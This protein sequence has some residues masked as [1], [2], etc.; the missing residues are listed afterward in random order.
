MNLLQDSLKTYLQALQNALAAGDATEHTHRPALEK[1]FISFSVPGSN[2]VEKVRYVVPPEQPGAAVLHQ[3]VEQAPSPVSVAGRVYIN[4]QQF[5]E[6][7]PPEA[8]AFQVGGYQVIQKWL[9]DRK[10]RTLTFA[11]LHH[12][13]KVVMPLAETIRLMAEIDAAIEA[14]GGWPDAFADGASGHS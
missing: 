1:P 5:F 12:Y 3:N 10:G 9:K 4:D 14:R 13:Q 6:R 7:M 2:L 11:E 8:W